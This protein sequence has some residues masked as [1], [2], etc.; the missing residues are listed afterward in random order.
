MA[1]YRLLDECAS[2]GPDVTVARL[3]GWPTDPWLTDGTGDY[4]RLASVV[5]ES[6][7]MIGAL[8][9]RAES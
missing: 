6:N 3:S 5:G 1:P 8:P 4:C 2:T 7:W 9:A